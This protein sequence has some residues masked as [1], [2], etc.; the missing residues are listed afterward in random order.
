MPELRY[1]VPDWSLAT[2]IALTFLRSIRLDIHRPVVARHHGL[3][4]WSSTKLPRARP[5][6]EQVDTR[7]NQ[8]ACQ[9][10]EKSLDIAGAG[11]FAKQPRASHEIN[12]CACNTCRL[13]RRK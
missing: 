5:V 2:Y 10:R 11:S 13:S 7:T 6:S 4:T 8:I 12:P 3:D 1:T 9:K